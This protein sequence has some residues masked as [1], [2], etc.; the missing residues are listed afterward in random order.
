MKYRF[1]A[2][3]AFWR[4]FTR[5]PTQQ[6][7]HAR[8]AFAIFKNNPFDPR[9]SSHKIQSF[10]SVWS[11]HLRPSSPKI[12]RGRAHIGAANRQLLRNAITD[13][14]IACD[15]DPVLFTDSGQPF[16]IESILPKMI[17]VYLDVK[18]GCPKNRRHL[19][20]AK[21]PN[22]ERRLALQAAS[23]RLSSQ[24]IASSIFSRAQP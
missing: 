6:Q 4:S 8:K 11:G 10:R 12:A 13:T 21:L 23:A 5:L 18:V 19:V 2:T 15:N 20:T 22:R 16:R 9:L 7:H 3:R 24:R 1:R 14:L 17:V